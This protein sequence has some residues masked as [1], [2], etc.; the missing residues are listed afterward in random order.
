MAIKTNKTS[1]NVNKSSKDNKE[2]FTNIPDTTH[3]SPDFIFFYVPPPS[4]SLPGVNY[5]FHLLENFSAGRMIGPPRYS[6]NIDRPPHTS[7][8]TQQVNWQINQASGTG[9]SNER[10]A[11]RKYMTA[12]KLPPAPQYTFLAHTALN[13]RFRNQPPRQHYVH[14][15]APETDK[16]SRKSLTDGY[17]PTSVPCKAKTTRRQKPNARTENRASRK[18][19]KCIFTVRR[20]GINS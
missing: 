7:Y 14:T 2:L 19:L 18:R 6:A 1:P 11:Q 12:I 10:G 17:Q 3:P 8:V 13:A 16:R 9:V 15:D 4:C 5:K 20:N